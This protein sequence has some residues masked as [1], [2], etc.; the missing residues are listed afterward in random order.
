MSEREQTTVL[1]TGMGSANSVAIVKGLRLDRELNVRVVGTDIFR[2]DE[3]AG[4]FFCDEFY[5][6]PLATQP[7]YIETLLGICERERVGVMFPVIEPELPAIAARRDEFEARGVFVWV[8]DLVTIQTCNDKMNTFR[9]CREHGFP[10][11]QT[12]TA[13]E[14]VGREAQLPYPVFVKPKDG[15]GSIGATA[16]HSVSALADALKGCKE[17]IV[18]AFAYGD[19]YTI[20]TASDAEGRV[21]ACVPRERIATK[22]G[23][24]HKGRTVHDPDLI[25]LTT[26]LVTAL[27]IRGAC[28]TQIRVNRNQLGTVTNT[29]NGGS[30]M[31]IIDIN[32]RF[33]GALPLTI[34]AGVNSPVLLTRLALGESLDKN[35]YEFQAGVY[36]A[37]H[38]EEVFLY[39]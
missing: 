32:P 11:P 24:T 39:R 37:R 27:K 38:W 3:I 2:R 20:D 9:F 26:R 35:Y 36:M 12:W 31:Q 17:P 5:T 8:S 22:A 19:E 21:F 30:A 10:T 25:E 33:P 28:N 14:I 29:E 1:V 6:V 34:A 13:A 23:V 15:N 18:Q 4:S 16:V 7:N